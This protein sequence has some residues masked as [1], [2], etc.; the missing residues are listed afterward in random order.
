V[1]EEVEGR[2]EGRLRQWTRVDA[3]GAHEIRPFRLATADA[4]ALRE[5]KQLHGLMKR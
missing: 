3:A 4:P 1:P 2:A 5:G